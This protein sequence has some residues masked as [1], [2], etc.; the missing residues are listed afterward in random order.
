MQLILFL[1]LVVAIVILYAGVKDLNKKIKH[2]I[3]VALVLVFILGGVYSFVVDRKTL[4]NREV[5]KNFN[6]GQTL[7]SK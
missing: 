6:Q 7:I 4:G 3:V 5:V 1:A 2:S